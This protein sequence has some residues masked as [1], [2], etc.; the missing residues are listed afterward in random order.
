MK[1]HE[2][3]AV[4]DHD[5]FDRG[6]VAGLVCSRAVADEE[7]DQFHGCAAP[8]RRPRFCYWDYMHLAMD[9]ND[10]PVGRD[11]KHAVMELGRVSIPLGMRQ[12]HRYALA[13]PDTTELPHPGIG[14]RLDPPGAD[15]IG[16][17]VATET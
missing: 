10:R 11:D 6:K 12:E 16:K 15:T 8:R 14:W 2:L 3:C 13:G 1:G 4:F 17:F 5:T 7:R 9:A